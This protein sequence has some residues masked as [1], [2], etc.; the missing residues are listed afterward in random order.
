[1]GDFFATQYPRLTAMLILLA[2]SA[3]FS[4][5]ETA[6]FSLSRDRLRR[7]RQGPHRLE[8]LVA[9]LVARP[10]S[11]LVTILFGN[12][13]VNI[14]FY[15]FSS[16]LIWDIGQRY[17]GGWPGMAGVAVLLTVVVFGE[18]AP[19]T[20]AA[21]APA[22]LARLVGVP[23]YLLSRVLRPVT[24]LL[25]RCIIE[26]ATRLA[27]GRREARGGGPLLTADE[28]QAIVDLAS[29]EGVVDR[30]EGEMIGEVLRLHETKVRE[31]MVPRVDMATCDVS[32]PVGELVETFRRTRHKRVVVCRDSPD[33]VIGLLSAR[34]VFLHPDRPAAELVEPVHFVPEQ[35]TVE[36]LLKVFRERKIQIAVVVDEYGGTAGLVTLEDCLEEIVG[37][38]HDEHDRPQAPVER[39]SERRFLLAGDLGMRAWRDFLLAELDTEMDVA[40]LGGFVTGLLGRIPRQGDS[41]S[42]GNL[43]FTVEEVSHR[44]GK[45]F[46]RPLK[47]LVEILD[48]PGGP[49]E[50]AA[51]GPA[52]GGG[53]DGR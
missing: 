43:R 51:G 27:T 16:G 18:V 15:A 49:A 20:I 50:T 47:I 22:P 13:L 17:G 41:C 39:L 29:D 53:H 5:S 28:L 52:G 25:D 9:R 38:I 6:L 40:T 21:T 44:P 46:G 35:Q 24:W 30:D 2:M 4:G 7:F 42:Y 3:F 37:D 32:A 23:L 34:N 14:M 1:M 26:P 8:H 12:M 48:Q 11:L 33:E 36:M 19:K 45:A 10:R 31:V